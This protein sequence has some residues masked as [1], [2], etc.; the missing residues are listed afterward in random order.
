MLSDL[1]NLK[2]ENTKLEKKLK[3]NFFCDLESKVN[4]LNSDSKE[5]EEVHQREMELGKKYQKLQ[6]EYEELQ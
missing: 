6:K 5:L 4:E 1:K 3:Y 2:Y